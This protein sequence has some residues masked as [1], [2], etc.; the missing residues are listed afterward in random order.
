L[1]EF[2]IEEKE[3]PFPSQVLSKALK[4]VENRGV[5]KIS[6]RVYSVRSKYWGRKY[7]GQPSYMVEK[8]SSGKWSCTCPGFKKRGI[9]AHTV[10]VMIS[11][12]R[13]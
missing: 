2:K 4:L 5:S 10:A 8:I 9:C 1:S 11:E 13:Q 6:D 12:S 3:R 7:R